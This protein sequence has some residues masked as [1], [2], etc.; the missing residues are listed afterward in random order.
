M[1]HKLLWIQLIRNFLSLTLLVLIPSCLRNYGQYKALFHHQHLK[2]D[3]LE[4]RRCST[5][6]TKTMKKIKSW[7]NYE[8]SLIRINFWIIMKTRKFTL[9]SDM[10]F[11][12]FFLLRRSKHRWQLFGLKT[13]DKRSPM[14]NRTSPTPRPPT[15]QVE[16]VHNER[17]NEIYSSNQ[18][19]WPKKAFTGSAWDNNWIGRARKKNKLRHRVSS[20]DYR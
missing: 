18:T 4:S 10:K 5:E 6:L 7:N 16:L 19:T 2:H 14:R 13:N 3:T 9:F 11:K 15:Q 1:Q 20:C 12:F 8:Q 17:L